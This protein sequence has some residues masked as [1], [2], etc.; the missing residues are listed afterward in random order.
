MRVKIK[1][2]YYLIIVLSGIERAS[3]KMEFTA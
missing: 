1:N 3:L 2:Y